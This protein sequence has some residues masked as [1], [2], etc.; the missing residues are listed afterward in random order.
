MFNI[1][2]VYSLL[3]FS[4]CT[5]TSLS[6]VSSVKQGVVLTR[7]IQALQSLISLC[8]LELDFVCM[9]V[10]ANKCACWR[11]G[12]RYKN[13]CASVMVRGLPVNW[14]T[15]ARYLGELKCSF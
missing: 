12:P 1:R 5:T 9:A 6:P 4:S 2:V 7:R 8:E 13:A 10:N 15:S 14:V 3:H 11:F